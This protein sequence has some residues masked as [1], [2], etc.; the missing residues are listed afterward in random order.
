M[1]IIILP[2]LVE[3]SEIAMTSPTGEWGT[4][5][6][7]T[8]ESR[9]KTGWRGRMKVLRLGFQGAKLLVSR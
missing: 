5:P 7:S 2:K 6:V 3:R 8:K 1:G 9:G 4:D